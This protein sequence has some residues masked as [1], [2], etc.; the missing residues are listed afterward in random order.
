MG[1]E[2]FGV[3]VAGI[4][5]D[6]LGDGL[7]D[8]TITR[9]AAGARQAGNLTGGRKPAPP[10]KFSCKGFWDD[11]SGPQPG[12]DLEVGDRKAVLIGD[13]IPAAALPIQRNDLITVHEDG[14]D[15]SLYVE[16]PVRRDPAAATYEFQC[17][18]RRGPD[19][20]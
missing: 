3:D 11:F 18:D 13:T 17:R 19:K 20:V 12:I 9:A 6:A 14:G 1:N 7:P 4:I 5:A 10:Q 2:L 8:V 16:K 15:V